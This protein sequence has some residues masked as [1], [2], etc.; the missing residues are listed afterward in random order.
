MLATCVLL[1]RREVTLCIKILPEVASFTFYLW[2]WNISEFQQKMAKSRP[3][4][5]HLEAIGISLPDKKVTFLFI[6]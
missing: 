3:K 2:L 6:I 5:N 1:S 4:L